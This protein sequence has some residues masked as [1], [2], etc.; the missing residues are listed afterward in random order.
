MRNL[1][2]KQSL[3]HAVGEGLGGGRS[4]ARR[5]FANSTALTP[6]LSRLRE[7]AG[8]RA[9]ELAKHR[10]AKLRPP[11]NP[12]PTAWER[13]CFGARF[14][15]Q[16]SHHAFVTPPLLV[17]LPGSSRPPILPRARATSTARSGD[18]LASSL[19]LR[20]Y[21]SRTAPPIPRG[22]R[23]PALSFRRRVDAPPARRG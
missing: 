20:R 3:S 19:Q 1:A 22:T 7:R 2:P 23:H 5:C 13:D 17:R 4:F 15:I 11:P 14:R 18:R 9:V 21:F 8:V 12:S 6:A 16:S 10:R